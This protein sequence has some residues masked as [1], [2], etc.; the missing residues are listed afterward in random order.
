MKTLLKKIFTVYLLVSAVHSAPA[1]SEE[2][3]ESKQGITYT[4]PVKVE[5]V[6]KEEIVT[7]DEEN[8]VEIF[9]SV[10]SDDVDIVEDFD[11][12]IE[13]MVPRDSDSC[14]VLPLNMEENIPPAELKFS[15]ESAKPE[16]ES[17]KDKGTTYKYY[18]LAGNAI[19]N[20]SVVGDTIAEK[21]LGRDIF[22]L[23]PLP[24]GDHARGKRGCSVGCGCACG[25]SCT[26][27][28][29]IRCQLY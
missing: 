22:W 23:K 6:E 8:D 2:Q 25:S 5:G 16:D 27:D 12:G 17:A 18:T 14:Y 7:I 26:C 10:G 28:C 1:E 15:I 19:K 29:W 20:R 21:C 9:K 24:R 11:A 13:G 4:I 3:K